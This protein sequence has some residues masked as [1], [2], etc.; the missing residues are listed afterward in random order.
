MQRNVVVI[1]Q[2]TEMHELLASMKFKI[3]EA[4]NCIDGIRKIIRYSPDLVIG[5]I[6]IPN[7]NGLSMAR[8]LSIL[9]IN[10]PLILTSYME[11]YRE[12]ASAFSN[13]AGFLMNPTNF[14]DKQRLVFGKEFQSIWEKLDDWGIG[15]SE[16]QYRFRQHEWANLLGLSSRKKLLLVEDD[17]VFKTLTLRKLDYANNYKLFSAQDGLEGVF[18]A[19]LLEPDLIL[20]DIMMP[21]L[22][23][24]AMSQIFYILNKPFPIVFLTA[25]DD[26]ESKAKAQ[27]TMGALGYMN[28]RIL[29]DGDL[30]LQSVEKYIKKAELIKPLS[31]KMYQKGDSELLTKNG[32]TEG[33]LMEKTQE[34]S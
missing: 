32:G 22:D 34:V 30:F 2:T 5:E 21:K 8:I 14:T 15:T 23:G 28:K 25:K 10:V 27:K 29:K 7:L 19:L 11:K 13:V 18:K 1:Q 24:M 20:T 12:P 6:N 17:A 9:Q 4:R 3:M 26:K 33:I 16:Y 31:T